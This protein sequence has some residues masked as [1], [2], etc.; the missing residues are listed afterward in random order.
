M[1]LLFCNGK[2]G[3][4][5]LEAAEPVRFVLSIH[6]FV[7]GTW[8]VLCIV[9]KI[10]IPLLKYKA[11][12]AFCLGIPEKDSPNSNINFCLWILVAGFGCNTKSTT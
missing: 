6:I 10:L 7:S 11:G 12:P 2:C 8:I 3:P 9:R 5:F 1:F 4:L